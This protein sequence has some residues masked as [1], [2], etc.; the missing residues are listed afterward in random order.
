MKFLTTHWTITARVKSLIGFA[1]GYAALVE[2]MI[3]LW[4]HYS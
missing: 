1:I 4:R 3:L 2:I